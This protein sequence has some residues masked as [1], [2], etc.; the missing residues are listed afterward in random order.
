MSA[1]FLL[2]SFNKNTVVYKS[3]NEKN[4]ILPDLNNYKKVNL[5][6][7]VMAGVDYRFTDKLSLRLMPSFK[8]GLFVINSAPIVANLWSYGVNIGAYY[9]L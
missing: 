3:G 1:N 7:V 4:H 2:S 6:S 5:S 8:Y 9:R